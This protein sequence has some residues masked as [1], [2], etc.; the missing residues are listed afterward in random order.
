MDLNEILAEGVR[1]EASDVLLKVGVAPAFRIRSDFLPL[2]G[3]QPLTVEDLERLVG[4]LVSPQR[5]QRL[6]KELQIDLAYSHAELGRFRVN[7]FRQRGCWSAVIRVWTSHA[8]RCA[9]VIGAV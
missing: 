5:R 7:V 2:E 9:S 8:R 6:D 4:Q 3:A 1:N